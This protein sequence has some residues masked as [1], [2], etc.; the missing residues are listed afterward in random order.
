[1]SQNKVFMGETPCPVIQLPTPSSVVIGAFARTYIS[2]SLIISRP[3]QMATHPVL[4]FRQR[5]TF[6]RLILKLLES[7]TLQWSEFVSLLAKHLDDLHEKHIQ[8]F[9]RVVCNLSSPIPE[10]R[11]L[12]ALAEEQKLIEEISQLPAA[13]IKPGQMLG[14]FF[15]NLYLSYRETDL[16]SLE[17]LSQA[18]KQYFGKGREQWLRVWKSLSAGENSK[19]D[20]SRMTE[21]LDASIPEPKLHLTED[22]SMGG[23]ED[24][25]TVEESTVEEGEVEETTVEEG[26]V[27]E[28]TVEEG[29]VEETT[30]EEGEVEGGE[31]E[32]TTVEE[33]EVEGGVVEETTV[34]EDCEVEEATL[35]FQS[36][37]ID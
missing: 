6:C 11:A 13:V 21:A 24:E 31:V 8:S 1:M 20:L 5:A 18:L 34:E 19:L 33:G 23:S 29:E 17:G 7:P 35:E 22:T 10:G 16:D 27:E 15:R 30:V 32:E 25:E 14:K 12:L 36:P 26:E 3:F 2:L 4:S 37:R 9:I 28:T